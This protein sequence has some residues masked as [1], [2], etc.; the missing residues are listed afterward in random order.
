MRRGICFWLLR[1]QRILKRSDAG[2]K[3][4]SYVCACIR[5]R[6]R[7]HW[8]HLGSRMLPLSWFSICVRECAQSAHLLSPAT[9]YL[10][11]GWANKSGARILRS[12]NL[13]NSSVMGLPA[14]P[15]SPSQVMDSYGFSRQ[16]CN[17]KNLE[18]RSLG[19]SEVCTPPPPSLCNVS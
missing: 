19:A 11:L 3:Y 16:E 14:T 8:V 6:A 1:L 18:N 5:A 13:L 4:G 15:L 7:V 10:P 12:H 17:R 9:P 2:Q